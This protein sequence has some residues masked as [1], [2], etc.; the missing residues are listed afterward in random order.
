MWHSGVLLFQSKVRS[1]LSVRENLATPL[2]M[3]LCLGT[4]CRSP[5]EGD[6]KEQG[7][8]GGDV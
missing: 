8:T 7:C 4:G 1:V 2:L 3:C 6:L 5:V